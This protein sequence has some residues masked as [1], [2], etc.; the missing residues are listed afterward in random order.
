LLK[1]ANLYERFKT[2]LFVIVRDIVN[3]KIINKCI[4][5]FIYIVDINEVVLETCL[6][7]TKSI[8]ANIIL[9]ND[10]LELS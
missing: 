5:L 2:I 8:K 1:D 10:I 3:E 7:I 4:Y 9:H 6:Y